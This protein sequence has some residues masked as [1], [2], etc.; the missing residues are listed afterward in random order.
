MSQ[1]TM[2]INTLTLS[3]TIGYV[4]THALGNR[5]LYELSLAVN[6]YSKGE[7]QTSWF[8]VKYL[9]SADS[10][11]KLRVGTIIVLSG[12]LEANI[13]QPRGCNVPVKDL[14]AVA[15]IIKVIN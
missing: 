12:H 1:N 14:F 6:R 15:E 7:E 13:W 8:P 4:Q 11:L 3:G 9:C 5:R 2:D 10:K